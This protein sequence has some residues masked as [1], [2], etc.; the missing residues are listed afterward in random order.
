VTA[1]RD[2]LVFC[3]EFWNITFK[4]MTVPSFSVITNLLFEIKIP[5]K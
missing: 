3:G 2:I 5:K 4:D 1:V